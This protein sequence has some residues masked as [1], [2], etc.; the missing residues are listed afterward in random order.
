MSHIASIID[1]Q[2]TF[3]SVCSYLTPRKGSNDTRSLLTVAPVLTQGE[4]PVYK[5]EV[6][7]SYSETLI[8]VVLFKQPLLLSKTLG[9]YLKL[10]VTN[11]RDEKDQ[12]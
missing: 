1:L 3:S 7:I 6:P 10:W 5:V 8:M 11:R 12:D 9:Q 4:M 2:A